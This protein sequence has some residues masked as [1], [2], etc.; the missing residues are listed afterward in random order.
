MFSEFSVVALQREFAEE[1]VFIS[2]AGPQKDAFVL[3][4]RQ[5]LQARGTTTFVDERDIRRGQPSEQRMMAACQGAKVAIVVLT[6][7]FLSRAYCMEEVRWVLEQRESSSKGPSKKALPELLVVL[8]P[9]SALPS[10]SQPD[11]GKCQRMI[12]KQKEPIDVDDLSP[13]S[14][15]LTELLRCHQQQQQQPQALRQPQ[16]QMQIA[17]TCVAATS[18]ATAAATAAAVALIAP[19][20]PQAGITAAAVLAAAAAATV[21]SAAATAALVTELHLRRPVQ[22][23]LGAASQK[24]TADDVHLQQYRDDLAALAAVCVMRANAFGRCRFS[25][26]ALLL[27][28]HITCFMFQ[29]PFKRTCHWICYHY[30]RRSL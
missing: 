13:L 19:A 28:W 1:S 12:D 7:D 24:S 30:V 6:R 9:D 4:L 15:E 16:Y 22:P 8:Y 29:L 26:P 14:P 3:P 11:V 17:A 5:I 10:Y 21:A 25:I 2:H 23:V 20:A 27:L 18:A